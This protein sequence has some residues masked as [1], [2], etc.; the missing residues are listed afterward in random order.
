M[1]YRLFLYKPA[2][3]HDEYALEERISKINS[4][5]QDHYECLLQGE[6]AAPFLARIKSDLG[7]AKI[8]MIEQEVKLCFQEETSKFARGTVYIK[9]ADDRRA[10]FFISMPYLTAAFTLATLKL[11]ALRYRLVIY[12]PQ[13]QDYQSNN[14]KGTSKN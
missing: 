9:K 6:T 3:C 1:P 14:H 11:I 12:D 2:F 5:L 10:I 4:A 13:T 7:A 8:E